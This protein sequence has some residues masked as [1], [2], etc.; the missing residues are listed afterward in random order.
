MLCSDVHT[1]VKQS[2]S[3]QCIGCQITGVFVES[4]WYWWAA[5]VQKVVERIP[6]AWRSISG[7]RANVAESS[8]LLDKLRAEARDRA[9]MHPAGVKASLPFQQHM[10][11]RPS[12][13]PQY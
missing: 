2:I 6:S 5:V 7:S 11:Q 1:M 8:P 12:G 13:R 10:Q 9:T 3:L 4:Y